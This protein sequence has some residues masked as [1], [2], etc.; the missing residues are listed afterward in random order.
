MTSLLASSASAEQILVASGHDEY[1][2]F[3]WRQGDKII[4]VGADLTTMI[5]AE[6]GIKVES[7][8]VGAW[9]RVLRQAGAGQ[10][11]LIV[12]AYKTFEREGYLHFPQEHYLAEP[13]V[14]FVNKA[15]PIKFELWQDLVDKRGGT[16]R[17]ESFGDTFDA[18]A[19]HNLSLQRVIG[20]SQ[21][22]KMMKRN[23]LDYSIYAKYPGKIRLIEMGLTGD[24][25]PLPILIDAPL[26]F[27][28]FSKKSP[29]VK[30]IPYFSRRIKELKAD[31]TVDRLIKKYMQRWKTEYH[32]PEKT[33]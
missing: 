7:R 26:A 20:I 4:G 8:Y 15:K 16:V 2:P 25:I 19:E 33:R 32:N 27:Q 23:R 12:G 22:F 13:V 30:Y 28:A 10:I 14:V 11:D 1:P 29:F 3:M 17:G 31:G 18:F 21:S 5:F 24:I 6:L 9:E